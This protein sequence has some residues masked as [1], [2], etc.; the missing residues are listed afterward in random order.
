MWHLFHG[1]VT[2]NTQCTARLI[3]Q[4]YANW[5]QLNIIIVRCFCTWQYIIALYLVHDHKHIMRYDPEFCGSSSEGYDVTS[6]ITAAPITHTIAPSHVS[7]TIQLIQNNSFGNI[8]ILATRF[9]N[10]L[11]WWFECCCKLHAFFQNWCAQ[12]VY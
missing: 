9:W 3:M 12:L 1:S 7:C 4:I 11:T 8:L 6:S 10:G 2:C 5:S